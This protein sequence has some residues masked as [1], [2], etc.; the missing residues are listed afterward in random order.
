MFY[1]E[2]ANRRGEWTPVKAAV[3]PRV[4]DGR[5]KKAG[6]VGPRVRAVTRIADDHRNLTLD[7]L[8]AVYS[9]DG[10]LQATQ[11]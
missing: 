5:I 1:Y 11:P 3:A 6:F 10:A 8:A 2:Q 7:Q 9:P 4:R